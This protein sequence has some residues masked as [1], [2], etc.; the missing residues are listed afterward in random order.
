MNPKDDVLMI[1]RVMNGWV[2]T[3]SSVYNRREG[4]MDSGTFVAT[5][6]DALATLLREWAVAQEQK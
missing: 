5:T 2:V 3:V 6:P 4:F 1:Q